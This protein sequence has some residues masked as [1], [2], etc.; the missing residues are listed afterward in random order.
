[1]RKSSKIPEFYKNVQGN[2]PSL[3]LPLL[4]EQSEVYSEDWAS[5]ELSRL[6]KLYSFEKKYIDSGTRIIA[7]VDEVG[8]GPMA[9][10]VVAAAVVFE[11][12][13][14]LPGLDDSKKV[15][16]KIRETLCSIIKEE[17]VSYSIG[18]ADVSEIDRLNILNASLLAMSRALDGLKVK[19]ELVLVDGNQVIPNIDYNQETVVKGDSNV[20]SIALASIIA[21]VT[22]DRIMCELDLEYSGYNLARN[23]GYCTKDHMEALEKLRPSPIHRKSFAP[24]RNFLPKTEQLV[25]L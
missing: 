2:A 10:P 15:P 5:K 7:G 3:S 1:M 4:S 25:F 16:E 23:K 17:A 12:P 18:I 11:K 9:G 8:R 22:R 21:K 14:F 6:T 24:V 13:L 19:P 20:Y